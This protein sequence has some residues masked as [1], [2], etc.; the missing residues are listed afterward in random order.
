MT[1][2]CHGTSDERANGVSIQFVSEA[3]AETKVK[4]LRTKGH[5]REDEVIQSAIVKMIERPGVKPLLQSEGV[6]DLEA[7]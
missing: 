3:G 6:I 1:I 5:A 2:A 7:Q 4:T